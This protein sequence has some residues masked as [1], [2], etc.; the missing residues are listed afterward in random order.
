MCTVL[1]MVV[2]RYVYC[3]GHTGALICVLC[4]AWWC[5]D[6]CTVLGILVP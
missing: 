4:W 3:A 2:L 6:M 1:G 5:L